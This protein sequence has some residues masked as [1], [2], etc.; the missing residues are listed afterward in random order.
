MHDITRRDWLA[1][2]LAAAFGA[3]APA[4]GAQAPTAP[5]AVA[6]CS[7]YGAEVTPTHTLGHGFPD[8]VAGFRGVTY[9]LEVKMP[10]E[11]L[12][13]DEERWHRRW[14]GQVSIVYSEEDALRAIG[15]MN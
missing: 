13:E 3:A 8:L 6:R 15:A 12:T 10:G 4:R 2:T 9:L 11:H 7:S 5:V 1:G 14:S